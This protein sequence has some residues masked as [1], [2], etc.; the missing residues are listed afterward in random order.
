MP[1]EGETLCVIG[2]CL[3]LLAA[4]RSRR[5]RLCARSWPVRLGAPVRHL[6]RAIVAIAGWGLDQRDDNHIQIQLLEMEEIFT[7][8]LPEEHAKISET[9]NSLD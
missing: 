4:R 9:I 6:A 1:A 5:S 7:H 3:F 2:T 8:I